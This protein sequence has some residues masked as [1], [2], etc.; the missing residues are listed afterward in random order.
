MPVDGPEPLRAEERKR[1]HPDRAIPD[2]HPTQIVTNS[3]SSAV[4]AP[5]NRRVATSRVSLRKSAV[6][7]IV[8]RSPQSLKKS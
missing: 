4:C 3:T 5:K 7:G 8:P 1:S 2:E 6:R